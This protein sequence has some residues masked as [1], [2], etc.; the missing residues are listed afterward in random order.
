MEGGVLWRRY[1]GGNDDNF[2]GFKNYNMALNNIYDMIRQVE[3]EF[4]DW[5]DFVTIVY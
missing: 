1:G 5:A 3:G 2:E 4:E